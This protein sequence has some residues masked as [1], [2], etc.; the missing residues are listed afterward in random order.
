VLRCYVDGRYVDGRYIDWCNVFWS[1]V[2]Y[3]YF[4]RRMRRFCLLDLSGLA[5]RRGVCE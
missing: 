4:D 1:Y 3:G 5:E 2:S